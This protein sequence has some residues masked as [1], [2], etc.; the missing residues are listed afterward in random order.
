MR[1]LA[2]LYKWH[3]YL[4]LCG[5]HINRILIFRFLLKTLIGKELMFRHVVILY[6]KESRSSRKMLTVL[7]DVKIM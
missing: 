7:S 5:G 6:I 1:F 2:Y 3:K 4:Y